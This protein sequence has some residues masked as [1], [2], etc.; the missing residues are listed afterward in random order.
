MSMLAT[1][2][3]DFI[4]KGFIICADDNNHL[5]D[6]IMEL[7]NYKFFCHA[8]TLIE[9]DRH[10]FDSFDWLESKI[11]NGEIESYSDERIINEM[12]KLYYSATLPQYTN[13]L[14]TACSAN[15][16]SFF[17]EHY[18]ELD[19]FDYN[20]KTQQE[21]LSVLSRLDNEIGEGKNLGEIKE[22]VLLQWLNI[23]QNEPVFYFCSDDEGARNGVLTIEDINITCMSIPSSFVRL[24][25]SN[26][27]TT[28]TMQP[29]IESANQ[30]FRD[31]KIKTIC[32]AQPKNH[33]IHTKILSDDVFRDIHDDRFI[34]LKSGMLQYKPF[35]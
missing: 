20:H 31:H 32:V 16:Q 17:A 7:P 30:F 29:Y 15:K 11:H 9:L 28:E 25:K 21:Y 26:I 3:T 27:L 14:K 22:Y 1:L 8:Q 24:R 5:I 35:V 10:K 23:K 12:S 19:S 4:S 13:M 34:E 18:A 33:H 2:D 6:R